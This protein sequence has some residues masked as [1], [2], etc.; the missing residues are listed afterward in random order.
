L[1]GST[2]DNRL[3]LIINELDLKAESKSMPL[4]EAKR[5]AK[6]EADVSLAKHVRDEET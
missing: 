4:I 6:N 2:H 3:I 1:P 5:A